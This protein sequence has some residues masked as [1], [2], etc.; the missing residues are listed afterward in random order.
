MRL[1]VH[2]AEAKQ[3][4]VEQKT[5]NGVINKKKTFNTLS[6]KNVEPGN[7]DAILQQIQDEGNGIPMKHYLSGEKTP[8]LMHGKKK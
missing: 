4:T 8:G 1:T 5:K 7:V 3:D 6:F 2:V